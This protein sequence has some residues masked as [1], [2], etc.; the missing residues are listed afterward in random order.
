MATKKFW[1]RGQM[2]KLAKEA[3]IEPR[4]LSSILHRRRPVGKELS[5]KLEA[6]SRKVK[7]RRV[8]TA[9]DWLFSKYIPHP[10]FF[11]ARKFKPTK[12]KT[13]KK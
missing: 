6:A 13:G 1:K 9:F 2:A 8:I 7:T 12:R 10:A 5:V 11:N 4:N 3:G